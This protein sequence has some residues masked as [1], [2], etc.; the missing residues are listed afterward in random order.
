[1]LG[2]LDSKLP[3]CVVGSSGARISR[4]PS[5]IFRPLITDNLYHLPIFCAC[6]G[7]PLVFEEF[8]K[9]ST[10]PFDG[11]K[12]DNQER[13]QVFSDVFK[14]LQDS[15]KNGDVMRGAAYWMWDPIIQNESSPG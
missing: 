7:K 9:N 12:A 2:A 8:G 11:G 1:M 5:I 13:E 4:N 3:V 6:A 14:A 15:I 10:A